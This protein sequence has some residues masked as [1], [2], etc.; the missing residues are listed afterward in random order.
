[1]NKLMTGF[2]MR[3]YRWAASVV[4]RMG[5]DVFSGAASSVSP[6]SRARVREI[7]FPRNPASRTLRRIARPV[8]RGAAGRERGKKIRLREFPVIPCCEGKIE[9]FHSNFCGSSVA[10]NNRRI[11]G[12]RTGGIT[13]GLTGRISGGIQAAITGRRL[14]GS[15]EVVGFFG[16][17]EYAAKNLHSQ[18]PQTTTCI[19]RHDADPPAFGRLSAAR[20]SAKRNAFGTM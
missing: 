12:E 19:G 13:G 6:S 9:K 1:M 11:S 10:S 20:P 2:F 16:R 7:H 17:T 15:L 5:R 18:I 8:R 14:T 4:A 3:C